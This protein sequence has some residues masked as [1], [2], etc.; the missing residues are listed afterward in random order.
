M[1][2]VQSPPSASC[3]EETTQSELE[4]LLQW[5]KQL[6]L[7]P[8]FILDWLQRVDSCVPLLE[9]AASDENYK[10]A[11][12]LYQRLQQLGEVPLPTDIME[13]AV[14]V[15]LAF[16]RQAG[17]PAITPLLTWVVTQSSKTEQGIRTV[18]PVLIGLDNAHPSPSVAGLTPQMYLE[19]HY[20]AGVVY[21]AHQDYTLAHACFMQCLS[22][23]TNRVAMLQKLAY[24]KMCCLN[25]VVHQKPF[26][27]PRFFDSEIL[28]LP[29]VVP[30]AYLELGTQFELGQPRDLE[31]FITHHKSVFQQA[32][33]Y[34]LAKT[35]FVALRRHLLS[36]LLR[37]CTTIPLAKLADVLGYDL[38]EAM[39]IPEDL[40]NLLEKVMEA[41]NAQFRVE[42]H[43]EL[44]LVVYFEHLRRSKDTGDDSMPA[45]INSLAAG[46]HVLAQLNT[47]ERLL[48]VPST[49]INN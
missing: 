46:P 21:V 39:V 25:L 26:T 28:A 19:Y 12:G 4:Q 3:N 22:L 17:L 33:D 27:L 18:T 36:K 10:L 16:L 34:D 9:P 13:Q 49:G 40:R 31:K 43:P 5:T 29:S 20:Y 42:N 48:P 44:G 32:G 2:N 41:E 11:L 7:T 14:A 6:L 38:L 45:L 37:F 47:A 15:G 24:G 35:V 30:A 23:P 8:E 1:D